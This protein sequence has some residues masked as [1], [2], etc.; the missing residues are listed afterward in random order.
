MPSVAEF[1]AFFDRLHQSEEAGQDGWMAY[2]ARVRSELPGLQDA[3]RCE[4]LRE[5]P[6]YNIFRTLNVVHK[7]A[8]FHT[9]FLAHLLDPLA[10][11]GQGLLFL[12]CLFDCWKDRITPPP[13]AI[14]D[15]YWLVRPEFHVPA[16]GRLDLLIENASKKYVLVVENKTGT[17]D[18]DDQ[19]PRY[20]AWMD[21]YRQG[22]NGQLVYLTPNGRRPTFSD[23]RECLSRDRDIRACGP[24][25]SRS[26]RCKCLSYNREIRGFLTAASQRIGATRVRGIVEQ[27]LDI[28]DDLTEDYDDNNTSGNEASRVSDE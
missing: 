8:E 28:L 16:F 18:H 26:G 3:V 24:T 20:R 10:A 7:E 11:H 17:D 5:A 25:P 2:I 9:P 1:V 22:W 19:I 13:G 12:E 6:H 14:D 23:C 4:A 15:G 27:Y 21:R